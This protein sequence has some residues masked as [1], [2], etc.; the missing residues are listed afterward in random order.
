MYIYLYIYKP[1]FSVCLSV[2]Y[3][4]KTVRPPGLKFGT[5]ILNFLGSN[6][7]WVPLLPDNPLVP[8]SP[9]SF[10]CA[11]HLFFTVRVII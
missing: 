8:C 7:G 10:P 3:R 1:H 5:Q 6:I 9:N 11:K 4:L 2:P